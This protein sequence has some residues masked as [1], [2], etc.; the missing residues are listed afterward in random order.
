MIVAPSHDISCDDRLHGGHG[1]GQ[2]LHVGVDFLD[3]GAD[4]LEPFP[5]VA[6]ML[7]G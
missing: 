2:R 4:P 6:G 1:L 3:A 5:T 7:G